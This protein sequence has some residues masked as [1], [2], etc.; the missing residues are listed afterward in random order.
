MSCDLPEAQLWSWIDR[1]ASELDGHLEGCPACR[2]RAARIREDIRIISADMTE[3]VPLPE[4]VG[5]YRVKS[6]LGEGG[7]A[8]V[9]EAEQES[10]RR[11]IAL[12]VLRGGRFAGEKHVKHFLRETRTLAR[13]NHP[14]IAT[15]FEAGRTEDGLHYFAMELVGG[16]PLNR[17]LQEEDPGRDARLDLFIR[18][19]RA[20]DYAH[21]NG[22][23]HRDLKPTNIMVTDEGEPKVLDFGLAHMTQPDTELAVSL[24]RTGMMAGTPRYMSPEQIRGHR[25]EIGPATDVYSLG[26]ILYELLTNQPP[27]EAASF[28]P[29][30]V[31][32]ICEEA[33]VR[34]SRLDSSIR[35]DL[36]TIVL[37]ALAK[38]PEDRYATTS[39]LAGDLQLFRERKPIRARRPSAW[40]GVS[41]FLGRQ[42]VAVAVSAVILALGIC[43]AWFYT[44]PAFNLEQA[45]VSLLALRCEYFLDSP[46]NR[47]SR[48]HAMLA[49]EDYPG[50]PEG[51][52]LKAMALAA[53][54]EGGMAIRFLTQ[55]LAKDPD[56]WLYRAL[57]SSIGVVRDTALEASFAAWMASRPPGTEAD[58]WYLRTFT[59]FDQYEAHRF[60]LEALS[61]EPDHRLA[62][63]MSARAASMTG[64][65]AGGVVATSRLL[66]LGD[67]RRQ[68]LLTHRS[69]LLCRLGRPEEAHDDI[70]QLI[71]ENPQNTR[72]YMARAQIHRWLGQYELAAADCTEAIRLEEENDQPSGWLYYHRGTPH[73]ICGRLE[74]AVADY[75]RAYELLARITYGNVRLVVALHDLGRTAEAEVAMAEIR[76]RGTTDSWLQ[77]IVNCLAGDLSPE[78]LVAL[79]EA[80]QLQHVCEGYYYAGEVHRLQGRGEEALA[81]FREAVAVGQTIDQ[82]NYQDRLSEHELAQ[83]RL[84]SY[85]PDRNA[86]RVR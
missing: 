69:V 45:R 2:A 71:E 60:A 82:G 10:P 78:R 84:R 6:L 37:K 11:K 67:P 32:A 79:A 13:L 64:D 53:E 63:E 26:V 58:S 51:V 23:V 49:P 27:H 83:W 3:G 76:R 40:L 38:D 56:Q 24:T 41:K 1:E 19:C 73:L 25:S 36:E 14:A 77:A 29:E 35:G 72:N 12:K 62:L 74:D 66:E 18:I 46:G 20:V 55:E 17:Y 43:A 34:P 8:L 52:L 47:M 81:M 85:E 50:L 70:E 30:T 68:Y 75:Q 21:E 33:P 15:I 65:L 31:M 7:Q 44:R 57:M 42:R 39:D 28:T 5:N 9:Y 80:D 4:V 48:H 16:R 54:D 22:I 86:F 61:H 59:T